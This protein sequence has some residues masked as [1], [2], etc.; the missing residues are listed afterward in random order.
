MMRKMLVVGVLGVMLFSVLLTVPSSKG[1]SSGQQWGYIWVKDW[2]GSLNFEKNNVSVSFSGDVSGK[3]V[4]AL[5]ITYVGEENGYERFNYEGSYYSYGRAKG[6]LK[7]K[8]S[9]LDYEI[10]MNI[11]IKIKS[12]WI[13]FNGYFYLTKYTYATW[14]SLQEA[15]GIAELFTDY[16]TKKPLDIYEKLSGSVKSPNSTMSVGMDYRLTGT[17]S[18]SATTT[19]DDP[20]PYLPVNATGIDTYQDTDAHYTGVGVVHTS[21]H[22]T[23]NAYPLSSTVY[24][25][26]N[27]KKSLDGSTWVTA[28][29]NGNNTSYIRTGIIE[30]T[31]I[32]Y[33]YILS[34]NETMRKM[35]INFGNYLFSSLA[36]N[37]Q[38]KYDKVTGFY[39]QITMVPLG[40]GS[41]SI[42]SVLNSIDTMFEGGASQQATEND[43]KNVE[44]NAPS[45]YGYYQESIWELLMDYLLYIIIGIVVA[46]AVIVPLVLVRRRKKA[47]RVKQRT[48]HP[49]RYPSRPPVQQPPRQKISYGQAPPPQTQQPMRLGQQY[50][51]PQPPVQQQ[52]GQQVAYPPQYSQPPKPIQQY[53]QKQQ[54]GIEEK[55]RKLKELRD[56]GLL[57]DEE[58][59][60][61]KA[62]LL[63]KEGF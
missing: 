30:N 28:S 51:P 12:L 58:Y 59:E 31:G 27:T 7:I 50:P 9:T 48:T 61:K 29:M 45:I 1:W 18:V 54:G 16:Y 47:A 3:T 14:P 23:A 55:L 5:L 37:N 38:A 11:D 40:T 39:S 43:V 63:K 41:S 21:G 22:M 44:T 62:E 25:D 36:I 24:L 13:V 6:T 56:D 8:D 2:K 42:I 57:T 17:L 52:P 34:L 10:D 35:D 4:N 33:M 20:I 53:P 15:W 19:F 32:N 49:T 46:V 60:R 26:I